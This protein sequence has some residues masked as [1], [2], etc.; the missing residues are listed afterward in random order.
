MLYNS[1]RACQRYDGKCVAF[2]GV[3]GLGEHRKVCVNTVAT[4]LIMEV[5]NMKTSQSYDLVDSDCMM[6]FENLTFKCTSIW[7]GFDGRGD[8]AGWDYQVSLL[9]ECDCEAY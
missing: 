8:N 1:K 7:N 9:S 5:Q 3:F 2:Q 4:K 6:E